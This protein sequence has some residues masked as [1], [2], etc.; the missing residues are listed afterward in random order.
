MWLFLTGAWKAVNGLLSIMPPIILALALAGALATSCVEKTRF[1]HLT[2]TV[3]SDKKAR[4]VEDAQ[5]KINAA[6]AVTTAL[7]AAKIESEKLQK[8]KDDA[9][10]K[11]NSQLRAK[12]VDADRSRTELA[13]LRDQTANDR[14]RMSKASKQAVA[15]YAATASQLLDNCSREYQELADKAQGHAIDAGMIEAWPK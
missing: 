13:S 7:Q 15:D 3:A 11:A 8:V 14:L 4:A 1:D 2:K 6:N 9:L 10:T 12:S 5:A